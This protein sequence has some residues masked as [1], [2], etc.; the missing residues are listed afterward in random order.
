M[1]LANVL[2]AQNEKRLERVFSDPHTVQNNPGPTSTGPASGAVPNTPR[3]SSPGT[4]AGHGG[5]TPG[6][7]VGNNTY[8]PP[9]YYYNPRY[10]YFQDW[11]YPYRCSLFFSELQ[12]RYG[13]FYPTLFPT[14]RSNQELFL[15]KNS[16]K[17]ALKESMAY[18]KELMQTF[19]ELEE[20]T[21][22]PGAAVRNGETRKQVKALTA[23]I[24]GLSSKIRNDT[25][26]NLLDMRKDKDLMK[27]A[28]KGGSRSAEL[29]KLGA[30]IE[31]LHTELESMSNDNNPGVVSVK[32]YSSPSVRS[33]TKGIEK[34]AK[35]IESNT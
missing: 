9:G 8:Y 4:T 27:D 6:G 21:Q 20:L 15:T 18:T 11:F 16:V 33:I 12:F 13:A 31:Q 19:T 7:R 2:P 26:L 1:A 10:Y 5:Y 30:L 28:S 34:L 22:N 35:R 29:E 23:K 25:F 17:T 14:V 32:S 3:P 24:R